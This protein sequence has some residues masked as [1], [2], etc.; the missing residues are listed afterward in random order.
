M[1]T[2]VIRNGRREV[3]LDERTHGKWWYERIKNGPSQEQWLDKLKD[4]KRAVADWYPHAAGLYRSKDDAEA[5]EAI[6]TTR[7][8]LK[9]VR[10]SGFHGGLVR[11]SEVFWRDAF[12]PALERLVEL[13]E[14]GL[15][16]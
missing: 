7:E 1:N 2:V 11:L 14:D 10:E 4:W 3:I 6:N 15:D 12:E 8:I 16:G 13:A 9:M 5:R